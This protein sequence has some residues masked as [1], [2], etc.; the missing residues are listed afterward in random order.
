[1]PRVCRAI[2]L[3]AVH[4]LRHE[5]CPRSNSVGKL[6][7]EVTDIQGHAPFKDRGGLGGASYGLD[8]V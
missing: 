3:Y 1:M 2:R 4:L 6:P 5:S 7:I 8:M